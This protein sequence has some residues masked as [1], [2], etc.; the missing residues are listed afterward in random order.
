VRAAG[1]AAPEDNERENGATS[2]TGSSDCHRADLGLRRL[3]RG[4]IG[5]H[6]AGRNDGAHNSA[7]N[8][9]NASKN[10][11]LG[12]GAFT[13]ALILTVAAPVPWTTVVVLAG[14]LL[15][16]S[17]LGPLLARR[18]PATVLA[19]HQ[20][21]SASGWQSSS[22]STLCDALRILRIA[23]ERKIPKEI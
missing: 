19:G 17:L 14:G 11:Y 23:P 21:S 4:G 22:L 16:G 2:H 3:L 20:R 15:V 13:S 5:R 6:A 8:E 18:L 7:D 10:M 1:C 9:A 12:A